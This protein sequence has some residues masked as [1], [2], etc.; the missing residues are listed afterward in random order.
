MDVLGKLFGS[1]DIVKILRFFLLNPEEVYNA[2]DVIK[3]T[4]VKGE[5]VRQEIA[6]LL[7]IGFIKRRS[8]FKTIEQKRR[9]KTTTKRKRV[10]GFMLDREFEYLEG[11][12][13][14]AAGPRVL[15]TKEI[16]N[17]LRKAGR[18]KLVILTG[19]F[20]QRFE[21]PLDL[22]IVGE[23]LHKGT[24]ERAIRGIETELGREVRYAL[25][26]PHDFMYR[27]NIRD[28]LVRDALDYEH[29]TVI[30]RLGVEKI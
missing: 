23:R 5:V 6:M 26:S 29:E 11:L 16:L 25:L 13:A 1:K 27:L 20:L 28:R 3:R 9:K 4:K 2:E 19:A 30:D 22:L 17:R 10:P 14:L 24:L 7:S 12:Y 15:G 21:D 18:L 8:F